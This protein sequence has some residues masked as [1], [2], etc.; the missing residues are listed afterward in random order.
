MDELNNIDIARVSNLNFKILH[1]NWKTAFAELFVL[2]TTAMPGEVI[3]IVGPTR[4]GK[5]ELLRQLGDVVCGVGHGQGDE[6]PIVSIELVNDDAHAKFSFRSFIL[7][8]LEMVRHPFYSSGCAD[9]WGDAIV[10]SRI[11]RAREK[12]LNRA[13]IRALIQRR[14]RFLIIDEAQHMRYVSSQAMA[15]VGVM[16]ALKSMAKKANVV[17]I[18]AGTYPILEAINRSSHLE[19]RKYGVHLS[20]YHQTEADLAEFQ[21]ILAHYDAVLDLD[22]SLPSLMHCTKLLYRGTFGC[23]GLVRAWLYHASAVAAAHQKKIDLALLQETMKSPMQL[24]SIADEILTGETILGLTPCDALRSAVRPKAPIVATKKTRK[25]VTKPFQRKAKRFE[26][27][28][29]M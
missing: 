5:T 22:E 21:W 18:I 19:G 15:A 6:Q 17:L 7:Q 25:T 23:I 2:M 1:R 20:R 10:D 29:R 11:E 13:L 26:P 28:N 14:T 27:E 12:T 4:A 9:G 16:D 8:A 3:S 24:Y